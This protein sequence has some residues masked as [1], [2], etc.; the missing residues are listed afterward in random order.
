VLAI[1]GA[2]LAA[3]YAL[4]LGSLDGLPFQDVPNHL[5]RAVISADLLF[6]GGRRFGEYF[7]FRPMVSP[8]IAHDLPLAW[9]V[10]VLGP[11]AAGRAW[12]V[13]ALASLPAAV[14]VFLR[15]Y[16]C[17]PHA[18]LLGCLL[19][20]YLGTDFTFV[21]GFTAYRLALALTLATLAAWHVFLASGSRRALA[22][23]AAG[24]GAGYLMHLSATFFTALG[25]AVLTVLAVRRRPGALVVPTAVLRR[26]A[27]GL[28]PLLTVVAWEVSKAGV[29]PDGGTEWTK[30]LAK[31]TGTFL[32]F[33]RY[34][35]PTEAVLFGLF[36]TT[37][38]LLARR[39]DPAST[40]RALAP[41]ALSVVCFALYAALPF[42]RS[43]VA[44]IDLRALPFAWLFVALAAVRAGDRAR[45]S[46]AATLVALVLVAVNLGVLARHL[47]PQDEV[48]REYRQ[49]A[50]EMPEGVNFV[51]IATRPQ[52]GT[53][54]P[55]LHAG[56]FATIE[57]EARSPYLFSGG[58]TPHFRSRF[59][60][61]APSEFWYQQGWSPG[62]GPRLAEAYRYLLVMKPFDAARVPA[63]T[64]VLAGNRTAAILEVER[65]AAAL[66]EDLR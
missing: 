59:L 54:N 38:A 56:N 18:I 39:R 7:S 44:Y 55:Y 50:A 46:W 2:A 25:V 60:I 34:D 16:R 6:D 48:M 1:A 27:A 15:A 17:S 64:R 41:A 31:A 11:Y 62:D 63:R 35:L 33:H 61:T 22:A 32:P 43:Y 23:Y 51:P 19:S 9:L 45:P 58:V 14:A 30:P 49:V 20:L 13:I 12:M 3:G 29:A 42:S 21:I 40:R 8:Y 65:P 4:L 28:A 26:A 24:V 66:G 36:A 10:H 37:I 53:T 47:L 52:D 5:A 57:R